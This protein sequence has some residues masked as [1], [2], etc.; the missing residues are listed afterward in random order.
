MDKLQNILKNGTN[1]EK[2]SLFYFD[3][4]M[5]N[6]KILL[7]FNLWGRY[8]FPQFFKSEDAPFHKEMNLYNLQAYKGE[9][10]SFVN[11]AFRGAGKDVKTQLFMAYAILND[12]QH[13]RKYFKVLS[14]DGTNSTQSVTD[15]YNMLVNPKVTELYPNTF[16]KTVFKR[17]E[18]KDA[19]TTSF[20]VKVLADIVGSSQRGAKHKKLD[21]ILYGRMTLRQGKH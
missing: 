4:S 21:L 5:D 12:T 19:F 1:K 18:K 10:D 7:K 20:G 6:E 15:I 8:H 3:C 14:D 2:L 13:F 16:E 17:E 11:I 9:L